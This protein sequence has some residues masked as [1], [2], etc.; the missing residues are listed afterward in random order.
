MKN[1]ASTV[2]LLLL[3]YPVFGQSSGRSAD[4]SVFYFNSFQDYRDKNADSAMHYIRLLAADNS[5]NYLLQD[6]IHNHFA[7]SFRKDQEEKIDSVQKTRHKEQV[8]VSRQTLHLM[9]A[10]TTQNLVAASRP[11]YYW[12]QAQQYEKDTA[13]LH[14][15]ANDFINSQLSADD[16]YTNRVGRYALLIHQIIANNGKLNALSDRF[17]KIT[18]NK[19]KQNSVMEGNTDTL[20]Q[21]ML[22]KRS[23]YRYLYA[24][25]N[26]TLGYR[27]LE[28]GERKDAGKYLLTAY[29]YSPDGV[30][31]N[32]FSSYFYDMFFLLGKEK[33]TFQDD[34]IIYLKQDPSNKAEVLDRLLSLSLMDIIFKKELK[35][36]Y[37]DNFPG[38]EPFPV[39]WRNNINKGLRNAPCS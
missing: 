31:R 8:D 30:D 29:E 34:Y 1:F 28:N 25:C 19:L 24:Y 26:Y 33:G 5:Y 14:E 3:F 6:L 18:L 15:I 13:R 36:Y 4:G 38:R 10:D 32:Y 16:I 20:S 27:S 22:A 2:I 23:W 7:Q 39:F 21:G 35:A 9:V 17:L 12:V 11:V 37:M